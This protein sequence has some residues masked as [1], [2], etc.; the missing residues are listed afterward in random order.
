MSPILSSS[1]PRL[2]G[3]CC[4]WLLF[5]AGS[6]LGQSKIA[7]QANML[8][9]LGGGTPNAAALLDGDIRTAWFPGW[10][11]AHYPAVVVIDLRK[12]YDLAKIR[13]YDGTGVPILR[14]SGSLDNVQY[15]ALGELPLAQYQ[16]WQTYP[17]TATARYLKLELSSAQG[18]QMLGELE[19]FG[20][21]Y[22]G[23]A[24]ARIVLP[25]TPPARRYTGEAQKMGINGFHWVPLSLLTPFSYYREYQYW[26]WMEGTPG[27]NRFE[28][29]D[30][31]QGN[32][33]THY[34]AL[35]ENG[36]EP[37]VCVNRTPEWLLKGYPRKQ[38]YLDFKPVPFGES[39]LLPQSYRHFA[40]FLFQLA[41]R[42]GRNPVP[43][44]QLTLNP[45][46]LYNAAN[47]ATPPRSGLDLVRYIEVWNEPNKWWSDPEAI[48][49]P[50]EYAA[51]L[52]ACY[53]GHEGL[54]GKGYGIKTADTS[55]QV[56]MAGLAGLNTEYVRRMH[57]WFK[58]NRK[59]QRF[60]A[61]VVNFHHYSNKN[62]QLQVN[63]EE[64]IS[65]EED[66]F[67]EKLKTTFQVV[68]QWL[69]NKP[70]WLTEF[71]YDTHQSSPQRAR[72]IGKHTL[73][74]VQGR[75]LTR[76]YVEAIAAGADRV[77]AYNI[78]DEDTDKNGLFQSSGL[79]RS[80][81]AGNTKKDAWQ[82]IADLADK[83]D[84]ATLLADE[85]DAAQKMY[86]FTHLK[87]DFT[88]RW[89]KKDS[90]KALATPEKRLHAQSKPKKKSR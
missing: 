57:T 46:L 4:G 60:A 17:L 18:D 43:L 7:L 38:H 11:A 55:M 76:A 63:F 51:M 1:N 40:R 10:Q 70:I 66:N 16:Q 5:C 22:T 83:L 12:P 84:G 6:I 35:K 25:P 62:Q 61:D 71:G 53:D 2:R 31:G 75:W 14:L 56:V 30:G 26:S 82:Q 67:L 48:F 88:L 86:I 90:S 80:M 77:F 15:T 13:L 54:L 87:G 9:Q 45:T 21:P 27:L 37:V 79:A 41:A 69:P 24:T 74:T 32:F 58:A 78:V 44:A 64:G 28:P 81:K 34:K 85:S 49:S 52:S 33:D 50:E 73:E 42:Y 59:D 23:K 68:R 36:I 72:T 8:T 3:W 47:S 19:L 89:T 39:T 65:P 20:T 29:T